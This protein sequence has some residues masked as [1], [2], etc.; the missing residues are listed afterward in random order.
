VPNCWLDHFGE[1]VVVR[2][3]LGRRLLPTFPRA[4]LQRGCHPS[5]QQPP[6]VSQQHTMS[7]VPDQGMSE[8]IALLNIRTSR[9]DQACF[10]KTGYSI[11][12]SIF[13]N[14]KNGRQYFEGKLPADNRGNLNHVPQR[15]QPIKA[16]CE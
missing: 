5:V 12:Q 8:G 3:D 2:E 4:S 13:R 11:Q 7:N 15:R 9:H 16:R 14:I 6:L 10:A 1:R